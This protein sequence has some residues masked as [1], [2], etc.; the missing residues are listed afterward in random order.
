MSDE[1]DQHDHR[2]CLGEALAVAQAVAEAV[3]GKGRH[4]TF[5][6]LTGDEAKEFLKP[7]DERLRK[8]LVRQR[9][10]SQAR[11]N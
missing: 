9:K 10:A 6:V 4:Q 7:N 8:Y 1:K 11:W 3:F 2:Q 5:L